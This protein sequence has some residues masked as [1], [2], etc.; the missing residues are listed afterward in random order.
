VSERS[1]GPGVAIASVPRAVAQD[2]DRT[3]TRNRG[4]E[5]DDQVGSNCSQGTAVRPAAGGEVPSLFGTKVLALRGAVAD[6]EDPPRRR[7]PLQTRHVPRTVPDLRSRALR[8]QR[9]YR[10]ALVL[11]DLGAALLAVLLTADDPLPAAGAVPVLL[12]ALV[13]GR[14]YERRFLGQG[15]EEFRRL[16]AVGVVLVAAGSTFALATGDPLAR[17]AALG[18]LPAALGLC[19]LSHLLGRAS[20]RRMR[21]AGRCRQRAVVLGLE[22]SVA[23]LVRE[24][25]R[26][27]AGGVRVVAACVGRS[28]HTMIEGVPV[29]GG[30]ADVLRALH[31][32]GAD[33]VI[34][35]AWSEV[36]EEELRS[37]SWDLEG[38]AVRLLLAPRLREV[39]VPR[40]TVR[41]VAGVPLIDVE[42]PEFTGVRRVAKTALDYALALFALL[43]L[44]PVLLAVTLAVRLS[45]PGPV[46]FRQERV[47]RAGRRFRMHKFR[48]M[49]VD[50]EERLARLR[51]GNQGSGPMFKLHDDPRVTAVGRFLR[52]YSL[53]ELPQLFDVLLGRMSL[54]GPR[55]PLP[56]EVEEYE[57]AVHRRLLVKPGITGLW[58]V[59]GRSDLSWE[60]TVRLDLSYVENWSLGLD[61]RLIART[62]G[63][64]LS[65]DGAY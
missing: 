57:G 27:R 28:R 10:N 56:R 48:S 19:V 25:H 65:S 30:P 38:T 24:I 2:T 9:L 35:T 31:R 36:G 26:D 42:Q 13:L 15:P 18:T 60:E 50:A 51:G 53:D 58:Q 55:P 14:V 21:I 43:V 46:L 22:R 44:S 7:I 63:A 49:H 45:G 52:R 62:L 54:V 32:T 12:P 29:L 11:G 47:G 23:G 1:A 5:G 39:A 8:W 41:D 34:L 16:L 64:V 6:L 40:L 37:L 4:E 3:R 17:G 20:L 33:T 61:L 59:S